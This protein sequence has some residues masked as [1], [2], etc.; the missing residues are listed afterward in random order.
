MEARSAKFCSKGLFWASEGL[1]HCSLASVKFYNQ[2]TWHKYLG[3]K[4]LLQFLS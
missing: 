4:Y 2:T 3:S 1:A